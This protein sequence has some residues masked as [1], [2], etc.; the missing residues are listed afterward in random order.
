MDPRV[1]ILDLYIRGEVSSKVKDYTT[2]IK[3]IRETI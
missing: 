1:I 2:Y 3:E